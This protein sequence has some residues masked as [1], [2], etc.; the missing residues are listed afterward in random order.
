MLLFSSKGLYTT[1]KLD[2]SVRTEKKLLAVGIGRTEGKCPAS[3]E[4]LNILGYSGGHY[5]AHQS[6]H[7]SLSFLLGL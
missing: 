2:I 5:T 7:H 1:T 4:L 6:L 3:P